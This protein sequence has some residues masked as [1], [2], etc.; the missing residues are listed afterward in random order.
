MIENLIE[1]LNTAGVKPTANRILIARALDRAGN[2]MSLGDLE[3]R[4]ETIDRSNIF[5]TLS[6][7][8][9]HHLVHTI[10]DGSDSVKYELCRHNNATDDRDSDLHPHFYCEICRSTTCLDHIPIP[11]VALPSGYIS[12]SANYVVRGLCPA[13]AAKRG[14]S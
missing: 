8:R 5:R 2:P 4:L 12:L 6:L 7:F 3:E 1:Y 14:Q 13:C 11:P 9:K 10:N